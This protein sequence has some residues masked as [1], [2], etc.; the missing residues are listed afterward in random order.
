MHVGVRADCG[1]EVRDRW[2]G[3]G[4]DLGADHVDVRR[5]AAECWAGRL[6]VGADWARW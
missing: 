5:F 6:E 4:S 2:G 3:A 1:D